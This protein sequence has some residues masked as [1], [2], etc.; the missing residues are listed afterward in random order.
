VHRI[1]LYCTYT[2]ACEDLRGGGVL[3][4]YSFSGHESFP[5]R[6]AWLSKGVL[7]ILSRADLF[8]LGDAPVLLGVGKNMVSSIRHWCLALGMIEVEGRTGAAHATDLGTR[9][10]AP[11]GWDPFLEDIGTLWLLHWLLARGGERA[12]TWYLAF[13]QWNTS[14]FTRE[15]LTSWLMDVVR[16]SATTRATP[17]SLRRDVDV[18]VR[19][20]TQAHPTRDLSLEDTFDCPLVELGLIQEV[21]PRLFV[22]TRGSRPS[23]P[24]EI[25]AFA[26][27]DFWDRRFTQQRTL[28]FEAVQVGPGCPGSA[29]K[30]TEQ[31]LAERLETLPAWT[32]LS[33]DET[34]GTRVLLRM[35][36]GGALPLRSPMDAL[37]QYYGR[38]HSGIQQA[39]L[40]ET[41]AHG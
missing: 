24:D 23:L 7:G 14:A 39:P 19:S 26:L 18:F 2:L 3:E 28:S 12:S 29:F 40:W 16:E 38:D 20:Y 30:L 31:A 32:G 22:F 34:A 1:G 10:F 35:D 11:D 17:S 27:L 25:F 6:Y 37:Q 5:L 33:Y 9:F 15:E 36:S 21:E 41:A 8:T 13:T 4:R